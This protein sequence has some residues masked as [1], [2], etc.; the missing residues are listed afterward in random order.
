[1]DLLAAAGWGQAPKNGAELLALHLKKGQ[2]QMSHFTTS[3]TS[4]V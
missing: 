3:I 2:P 1:V 4:G